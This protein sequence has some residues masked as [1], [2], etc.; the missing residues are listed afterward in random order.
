MSVDVADDR[1]SGR[2]TAPSSNIFANT[3]GRPIFNMSLHL[4]SLST[5]EPHPLAAQPILDVPLD[6][7]RQQIYLD[8]QICDD[9]LFVMSRKNRGVRD[10][11]VGFQWTSGRVV[12]ALQAAPTQSFTSF[13]LLSPSS[14]V[15]P[16]IVQRIDASLGRITDL[17]DVSD[18]TFTYTLDLYTFPSF[19]LLPVEEL[20]RTPHIPTL[21]TMVKL[22]DFDYDL[23]NNVAPPMT[24]IRTDPPPRHQYASYPLHAPPPFRPDPE[25]GIA[26]IEIH[27]G[28]VDVHYVMI[29]QKEALLSRLPAHQP[30][31]GTKPTEVEWDAFSPEVRVFGP[32]ID[33]AGKWK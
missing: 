26:V 31:A 1:N 29:M 22:P 10:T 30:P 7:Y 6:L 32:D 12:M 19:A 13:V 27:T 16:T 3:G 33:E 20:P 4:Y 11:L 18:I 9:G 8:F 5:F 2:V 23:I 28:T 17:Q 14:F 15:I 25:S 21:C 24:A